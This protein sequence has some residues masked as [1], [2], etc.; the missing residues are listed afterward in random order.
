MNLCY[1][2]RYMDQ[3]DVWAISDVIL[4][5]KMNNFTLGKAN[6]QL[7]PKFLG[8]FKSKEFNEIEI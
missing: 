4:I 7:N 3:P 8:L 6:K 5:R 1:S 2:T